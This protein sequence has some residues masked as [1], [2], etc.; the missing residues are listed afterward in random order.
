MFIGLIGSNAS[1]G[2]SDAMTVI[3]AKTGRSPIVGHSSYITAHL[4]F[5]IIFIAPGLSRG[6]VH[7][8]LIS[9]CLFSHPHTLHPSL[10]HLTGLPNKPSSCLTQPKF[11]DFNQTSR[12]YLSRIEAFNTIS[13]QLGTQVYYEC[14]VAGQSHQSQAAERKY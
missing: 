4:H 13:E 12:R 6:D 7:N 14:T 5:L 1:K 3:L 9:F 10:A 11:P 8:D 2:P